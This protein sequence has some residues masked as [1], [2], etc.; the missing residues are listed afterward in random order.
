[1]NRHRKR[2]VVCLAGVFLLILTVFFMRVTS[3]ELG[4]SGSAVVE[5]SS[6]AACILTQY[7]PIIIFMVILIIALVRLEKD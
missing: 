1:M 7:I 5:N 2:V 6:S 3:A 4:P